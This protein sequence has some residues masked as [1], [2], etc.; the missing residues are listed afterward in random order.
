MVDLLFRA[1]HRKPFL[2]FALLLDALIPI[3]GAPI[4]WIG[5]TSRDP[6]TYQ[7]GFCRK[8]RDNRLQYYWV[9]S[10]LTKSG[11]VPFVCG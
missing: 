3:K 6:E 2:R 11:G 4:G 5:R 1:R 9:G 10:R 8:D 7:N